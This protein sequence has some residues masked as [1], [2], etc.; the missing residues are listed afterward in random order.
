MRTACHRPIP[1]A[2]DR[3]AAAVVPQHV[4]PTRACR[5]R[6]IRPWENHR[7]GERPG[8][9]ATVC[10]DG[11]ELDRGVVGASTAAADPTARDVDVA[12]GGSRDRERTRGIEV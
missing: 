12:P 2:L 11:G 5:P 9:D 6:V 7:C 10:V 8:A 3:P 4:E 1:R